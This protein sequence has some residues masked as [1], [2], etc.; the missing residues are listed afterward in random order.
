MKHFILSTLVTFILAGCSVPSANFP[1]TCQD[2][3]STRQLIYSEELNIPASGAHYSFWFTSTYYFDGVDYFFGLTPNNTIEVF[4]LSKKQHLQSLKFQAPDRISI[5]DFYVHSLDSIYAYSHEDYQ[6]FL[7]NFEGKILKKYRLNTKKAGKLHAQYK[8]AGLESI[9]ARI[10]YDSHNK[11]FYFPVAPGRFPHDDP[12][13]YTLRFIMVFDMIKEDFIDVVGKFPSN[14]GEG[15]STSLTQDGYSILP[16]KNSNFLINFFQSPYLFEFDWRTNEFV[17]AYCLDS[18]LF[19]G[20]FL[21]YSG[22]FG[23]VGYLIKYLTE[24]DR[25]GSLQAYNGGYFIIF[26]ERQS[27]TNL[28]MTTR[29]IFDSRWSIL[30]LDSAFQKVGETIFDGGKYSFRTVLATN[31]KLIINKDNVYNY[32]EDDENLLEFDSYRIEE[33]ITY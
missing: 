19:N 11:L 24:A 1:I 28:D 15:L 13:F 16:L 23:D 5:T 2:E 30:F 17:R 29:D 33:K 20:K 27:Y 3:A 9:G 12:D 21:P 14:F 10:K 6:M 18:Q 26:K 4:D 22:D 31:T 25:F 8:L 32:K 7:I